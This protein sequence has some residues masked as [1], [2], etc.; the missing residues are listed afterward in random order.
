[1]A[2]V[3]GEP[4]WL[5]KTEE[6]LARHLAAPGMG[7]TVQQQSV[8]PAARRAAADTLIVV[9]PTD[10]RK[11][12]AQA[13]PPLAT[14]RDGGPGEW[15]QR[16]LGVCRPGVRAGAA[17]GVTAEAGVGVGASPGL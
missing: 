17:A 13:M 6:R 2:R 15:V 7:R 5:K 8:V 3:L 1:V 12:Y 10:I 4:I 16:V 11:L 9:D 14:V